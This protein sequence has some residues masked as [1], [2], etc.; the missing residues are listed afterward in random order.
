MTAG[1]PAEARE[2]AGL[3]A[4]LRR[5]GVCWKRIQRIFGWRLSRRTL[6][7]M[8][9][10]F[11]VAGITSPRQAWGGGGE[12]LVLGAREAGAANPGAAAPPAYCAAPAGHEDPYR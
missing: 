3:V 8:V 7:R 12:V 5:C 6:Q 2:V 11:E 1:R 9:R 10:E 4:E